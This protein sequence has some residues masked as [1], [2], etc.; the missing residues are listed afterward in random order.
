MLKLS[1]MFVRFVQGGI[2]G[3]ISWLFQIQLM[4]TVGGATTRPRGEVSLTIPTDSEL[5]DVLVGEDAKSHLS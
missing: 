2:D 3:A 4:S 5:L 1:Y